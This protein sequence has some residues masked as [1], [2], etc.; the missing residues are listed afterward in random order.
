MGYKEKDMKKSICLII[1]AILAVSCVPSSK[2][3]ALETEN[4]NLKNQIDS[5][6]SNLE[7]CLNEL[8]HYKYAPDIL[9]AEAKTYIANKD[10]DNL[11]RICEELTKYHPQ[12]TEC[13]KATT[14][15]ETLDKEIAAKLAAEK[16]KRMKAV[17]K[18]KKRFDDVSGITWYENQYFVHYNNTNHTSIYIGKRETGKPWMRLKMSYYGDDWIFFEQ[19]YLSYDG[20]TRQVSFDRYRDRESDNSGGSVWEWIDVSVDES[21]I[22]FLRQLVD[23]KSVKMRLSG[24]YTHTKT[25]TTSEINGIRDVLLAYDVLLNGE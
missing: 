14:A 8:E 1:T 25:L 9:Y 19:A 13:K 22:S 16:A 24:K 5:L 11:A 7:L 4:A 10:R 21:M 20:N 12:S 17:T 15:L 18:L 6:R 3:A 23:G 2:Y